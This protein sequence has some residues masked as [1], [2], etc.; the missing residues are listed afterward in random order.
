MTSAVFRALCASPIEGRIQ[1]CRNFQ[2]ENSWGVWCRIQCQKNC[3]NFAEVLE[4]F[5][6]GWSA[7]FRVVLRAHVVV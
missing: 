4:D 2:L 7:S 1:F 6:V 5:S 3:Q